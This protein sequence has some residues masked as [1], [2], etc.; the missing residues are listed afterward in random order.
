MG[1][2]HGAWENPKP[3][4]D[5]VRKKSRRRNGGGGREVIRVHLKGPYLQ[6]AAVATGTL[7]VTKCF[8]KGAGRSQGDV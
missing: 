2:N 8:A 5:G 7:T 1:S 4:N 3:E 6:I